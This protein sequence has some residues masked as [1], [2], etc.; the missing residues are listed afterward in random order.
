MCEVVAYKRL[1]TIERNIIKQSALKSSGGR[2]QELVVYETPT[3][4][5][6]REVAAH[7]RSVVYFIVFVL[8]CSVYLQSFLA[9]C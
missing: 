6:L 1:K 9:F 8:F 4:K 7:G 3:V 2:L 5:A